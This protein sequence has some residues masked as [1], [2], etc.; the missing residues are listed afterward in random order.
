MNPP[1]VYELTRPRSQRIIKMT[2]MV[3]SMLLLL[4]P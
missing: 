3:S 4:L 1:M 2:A